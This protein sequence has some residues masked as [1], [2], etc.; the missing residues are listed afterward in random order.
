MNIMIY[1]WQHE[2]WKRLMSGKA[3]LPNALLLQGRGGIGKFRLAS[4]L[5]QALLCD[6]PLASGEPCEQ[7]GSCG[8]FKAGG[9]PDFRLL[10]PEAQSAATDATGEA[11]DQ[12]KS[13]DKKASQVITVTQVREL[14]DFVNLT[15][16]RNGM[17][18]ILIHPAEAMNPQ[19]ANALLKTLE[20]PPA[21]TLFILVSHHSQ[22]LLPTVRSRCQKVDVSLPDREAALIWLKEQG[23][24]ETSDCLAQSGYAPLAAL[25]FSDE[26]YQKSRDLIFAQLGAPNKLDPLSLAE[27]GEKLG[28]P[29][30]LHWMQQWVYDLASTSLTARARYQTEPPLDMIR[31]AKTVNLIELFKFQQELLAAQRTLHHPL[32]H[33]LL[34]EQLLFSYWQI[35]NRQEA[36]HV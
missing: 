8:W 4:I 30:M 16:H 36:A 10:E 26:G 29:W 1:P 7:C 3:N 2:I 14:A 12:A 6:S 22:R 35:V 20:E 5:A 24:A 28:L 27:Q 34:L 13:T 33:R 31:L 21:G 11:A 18:I 15:T 23:V 9:H 19:A 25:Q 32:N 17:R